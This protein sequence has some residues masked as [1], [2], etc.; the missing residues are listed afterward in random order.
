LLSANGFVRV[1]KRNEQQTLE[2]DFYALLARNAYF[3]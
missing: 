2:Y 1:Q 3:H